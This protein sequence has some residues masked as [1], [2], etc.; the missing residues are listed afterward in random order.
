VASTPFIK[1]DRASPQQ[2]AAWTRMSVEEK[3]ELAD[4]LRTSA[5]RLREAWLR[6]QEPGLS[7]EQIRVRLREYLLHGAA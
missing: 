1:P 5:L 3:L 6:K 7:D 4:Q 2:I